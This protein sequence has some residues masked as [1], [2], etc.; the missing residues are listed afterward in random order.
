VGPE[1][2]KPLVLTRDRLERIAQAVAQGKLPADPQEKQLAMEIA[3]LMKSR[4]RAAGHKAVES[5]VSK[6]TEDDWL[7]MGAAYRP[8]EI[9]SLVERVSEKAG[10]TYISP[11][12]TQRSRS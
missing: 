5:R 6:E 2:E 11:Q 3:L 1:T 10:K 9:Q 8:E 4:L 12:S 7:S